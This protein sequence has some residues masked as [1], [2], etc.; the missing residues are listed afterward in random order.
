MFCFSL[1]CLYAQFHELLLFTDCWNRLSH[2]EYGWNE[3]F[4]KNPGS[5]LTYVKNIFGWIFAVVWIW[6]FNSK[7][8]HI[9]EY[10]NFS[11]V[12]KIKSEITTSISI[13]YLKF[14]QKFGFSFQIDLFEFYFA[15]GKLPRIQLCCWVMWLIDRENTHVSLHVTW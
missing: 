12:L 4:I 14:E 8:I 15:F 13:F 10:M 7:C 11:S 9:N 5:S 2:K 1:F 6:I 3:F